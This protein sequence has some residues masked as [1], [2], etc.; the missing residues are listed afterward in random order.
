MGVARHIRGTWN[1]QEIENDLG[2]VRT[3]KWGSRTIDI[4]IVLFE[5]TKPQEE[6]FKNG[7]RV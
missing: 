2:R 1:E 6:E 4:D 7:L 5:L 3:E